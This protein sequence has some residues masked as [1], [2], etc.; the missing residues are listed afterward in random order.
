MIEAGQVTLGVKD[1]VGTLEF[2]HP[3]SNSLPGSLLAELADGVRA[4]AANE[5]VGVVVLRSAGNRA[6]C[7]GAS[8]EEL[9]A[10]SD[11]TSGTEFFMGFARL[12]LAMKACPKFVLV[13]VHGKAVGGGVGV[14]A[15][16]D[17]AFATQRAAIKLSELALGFGPFVVGPAVMRKLGA[18]PF[19]ALAVDT[20]WRDAQWA[21]NHGLYAHLHETAEE[22][23]QALDR[24]ASSLAHNHP[25]AMKLL[26]EA[27][28]EGT[29]HWEQL[30][31]ERAAM[32]GKLAI[33]PYT[34][35]AI[36]A[37]ER[38]T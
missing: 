17:V 1:R 12:I 11:E 26:K 37:F 30:L 19:S 22:M 13:R 21:H 3:K 33:S 23:D 9:K 10:I 14:A 25:A 16:A 38:R 20:G 7:A 35:E 28:W 27:T 8:F 5:D 32:S 6:F 24:L 36:A 31:P 15:A 2:S 34:Q 29:E 18:G 4:C